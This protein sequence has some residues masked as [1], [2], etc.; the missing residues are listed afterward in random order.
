M[1]A[2]LIFLLFAGLSLLSFACKNGT[3][4]TSPEFDHMGTPTPTP[5]PYVAP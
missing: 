1:K 4:S 5:M 2:I 3:Y